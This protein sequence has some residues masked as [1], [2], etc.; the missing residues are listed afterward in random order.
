MSTIE[1]PELIKTQPRPYTSISWQAF[2]ALWQR[3]RSPV[4]GVL[5]ELQV[6]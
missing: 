5:R 3:P 6:L 4:L 1:R 2:L